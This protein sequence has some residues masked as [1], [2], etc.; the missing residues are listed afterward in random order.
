M[1]GHRELTM[2]DYTAILRR[3]RWVILIPFLLG[4]LVA[5]GISLLVPNRYTSQTLV[6]IEQQKVPEN[7]VKSV[8]SDDLNVRL[9]T[10]QEQILSRTRLQPI[11]ERFGLYKNDAGKVPMED[12]VARLRKN[13]TISTITT[14]GANS[15]H[16]EEG[17]PGFTIAVTTGD[18]RTS[19][20]ICAEITSMFMSENLQAREQRAQGTTDFISKQLD[21]AKVNLDEQDKKLALFKMQYFGQLPGQEQSNMNIL[22][23]LN[24][25]LEAVTQMVNGAQQEKT[26]LGSLLTQQ[27]Q[28]WHAAQTSSNPDT[29][30]QQLGRMQDE[31]TAIRARYTDDYPDVIKVKTEVEQLKTRIQQAR[32]VPKEKTGEGNAGAE[33]AEPASIQQLRAQLQRSNEFIKSK[34]QEQER[35]QEEIKVYQARLQLSPKVEQQYKELTRDYDT[36]LGFYNDLL[37]KKNSSEMATDLEKRQ[38]G[39]QFRIMDPADLPEAPTFPNRPLF[40]LGGLGGGL[41]LG[42]G[43]A[44]LQEMRDRSLR[45]DRD[46]EFFLGVPVLAMMPLI[47]SKE[48]TKMGFWKRRRAGGTAAA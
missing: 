32:A 15:R 24:A 25:R 9:S 17:M 7:Y 38:Q 48:E 23:S 10:M 39:E 20:Q 45:T 47:E 19:Q 28:T 18:A 26:Y 14:I 21:E 4:P 43:I 22:S 33:Q 44:V 31:L 2:E 8:I 12:L 16:K 27:I 34:A 3:R 36:A 30:E 41:G 29:L 5:Y 37:G 35:L 13:I 11:I 42:L 6:L 1:L 46:V 40:A